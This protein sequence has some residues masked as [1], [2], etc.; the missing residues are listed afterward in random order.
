MLSRRVEFP[1]SAAPQP[2]DT[3]AYTFIVAGDLAAVDAESAAFNGTL[4]WS[5]ALLG[6]GLVLAV[7]LQVRIGLQPLRRLQESLARIRDGSAQ[8]LEGQFP[9]R[10]RAARRRAQFA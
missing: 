5:F 3:R 1:V 4:I 9:R 7:L 8:R 6:L 2:N 10:D